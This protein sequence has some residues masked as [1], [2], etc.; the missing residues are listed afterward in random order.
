M[1][2]YVP[3]KSERKFE[4]VSPR[5]PLINLI[6]SSNIPMDDMVY[7]LTIAGVYSLKN[8]MNYEN[9]KNIN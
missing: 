7:D 5:D 8:A 9:G 2:I 4:Y 1:H 6:T 3:V